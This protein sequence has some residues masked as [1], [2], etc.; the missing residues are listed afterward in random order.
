MQGAP[1][2][3]TKSVTATSGWHPVSEPRSAEGNAV[4]YDSPT[5]MHAK[6]APD[7]MACNA[8]MLLAGLLLITRAEA[9]QG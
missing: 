9:A 5:Q 4:D 6:A 2:T 3:A 7:S 1:E 8:A